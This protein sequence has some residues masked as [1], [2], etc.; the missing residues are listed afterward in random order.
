MFNTISHCGYVVIH[1]LVPVVLTWPLPVYVSMIPKKPLLGVLT[2][3]AV[4]FEACY[5]PAWRLAERLG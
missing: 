1:N 2:T 5:Y 4:V 3:A